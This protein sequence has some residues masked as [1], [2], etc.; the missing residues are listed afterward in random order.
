MLYWGPLR[1]LFLFHFL[2]KTV[3]VIAHKDWSNS[4][5]PDIR[6]PTSQVIGIIRGK[7]H[8]PSSPIS[9]ADVRLTHPRRGVALCL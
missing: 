3:V 4:A 7:W 8:S 2:L 9:A 1:L 5:Y 6:G